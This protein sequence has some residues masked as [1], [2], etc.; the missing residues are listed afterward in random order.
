LQSYHDSY[1]A[2]PVGEF[3][4]DNSNWGWGS[5]ILS[6]LDQQPLSESLEQC[7]WT[8]YT[9]FVPGGGGNVA[10]GQSLGF[11]ADTMNSSGVVNATA[12]N[13]AAKKPLQV[14]MCP[15][16]VWPDRNTAG[17]GKSNYLG[18]MGSDTSGGNWA[19]WSTPNGGTMNGI[20]LQSNNNYNTWTVR[21]AHITDGT[22]NTVAVGEV[23]PNQ[24][25]YTANNLDRVPMWA[26]GNPAFAGQ[27]RQHNY[28][29]LMDAAYP[30]NLQTGNADRC[31]GS[32]HTGGANFLFCDGTVRF[33]ATGVDGAAYQALG[34]RNGN[35]AVD[36]SGF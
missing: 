32:L 5:V 14:Y 13:G 23:A 35:E 7:K 20:L 21:I 9:V 31:F 11:N 18:N 3:N 2:F 27:G 25:S 17:Y 16:D 33:V 6:F 36:L 19:S 8:S 30:L 24:V 1:K 10:P 29:R 34:T 15:A 22:S 12:G 28:F 4:D 26:G